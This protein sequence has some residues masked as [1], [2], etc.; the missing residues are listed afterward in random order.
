MLANAAFSF[1]ESARKRL[2]SCGPELAVSH[3]RWRLM[4]PAL[5]TVESVLR[6]QICLR[7]SSMPLI[8]SLP[9]RAGEI[10]NQCLNRAGA[11]C[12]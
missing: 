1:E 7:V 10:T 5:L 12:R 11:E 8:Y 3:L 6:D 4:C 9:V 2:A